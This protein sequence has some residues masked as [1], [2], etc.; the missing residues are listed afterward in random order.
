MNNIFIKANEQGHTCIGSV[1]TGKGRTQSNVFIKSTA[2]SN[3]CIGSVMTGKGRT[4]SKTNFFT[5]LI[6]ILLLVLGVG[7][8]AWAATETYTFTSK[9]WGATKSG[10][11]TANW[12]S[13]KD[14]NQMQ[15]GRGIQVTT[16]ASGANGTS[17]VSFSNVSQVVVTYSTNA[18]SGAG[19]IAVKIGDNTAVSQSVTKS[20][21]TTDRTLTYNFS[22]NQTGNVKVTV[23]CTTNSIY[24]KSVA[25]TESSLEDRSISIDAS[26]MNFT[27]G[28]EP[29][30]RTGSLSAGT[31]TITYSSSDND[32]ATV[33]SSTGEVTP[34]GA[35]SC[36]ITASV[37]ADGIYAAASASYTVNVTDPNN[38]SGTINFNSSGTVKGTIKISAA[39]ASGDDNLDNTWSVTTVGTDS[40]TPQTGYCQV[41]SSSSPATSITFTMT[42][43]D[44]VTFKSFSGNFGGFSGTA[45]DITLKVDDNVVGTGSLVSGNND[46]T[47]TATALPADGRILTITITNISKGVICRSISYTYGDSSTPSV[48]LNKSE[49]SIEVG[50]TE[51]LTAT[52]KNPSDATVTWSTDNGSVATVS[53]A[54][55]VTAVGVGTAHIIVALESDNTVSDTCTVT[56]TAIPRTVSVDGSGTME[57]TVGGET[58]TRTASPSEGDDAVTYSSSDTRV[59]TVNPSTG[60]VTAVGDGSCT[61]TASVDESGNYA[62]ASATYTV[63]VTDPSLMTYTWNLTTSSYSSADVSSVQWTAE[64]ASMTLDKGESGTNAN[65]YLGGVDSHNQTRFYT[66]QNLTFAPETEYEIIKVEFTCSTESYATTLAGQTWDNASSVS[67]STKV[68]ITPTDRTQDFSCTLSGQV[69]GLG[70]TVYYKTVKEYAATI[71]G[72]SPASP[73]T[74]GNTGT[75]EV[76]V[77]YEADESTCTT[78]FAT[79]DGT[80]LSV[81]P[82]TG[83]FEALQNGNVDITVTITTSSTDYA[84]VS[85]TFNYTVMA[86]SVASDYVIDYN[87]LFMKCSQTANNKRFDYSEDCVLT[88]DGKKAIDPDPS[89]VWRIA[90][91]GDY[92]TIYNVAAKKYAASASGDNAVQLLSSGTADAALWTMVYDSDT[93]T[94]DFI[95][96]V[97]G[98]DSGNTFNQYLRNY[99]AYGFSCYKSGTGGS[100]TL[101]PIETG[102]WVYLNKRATGLDVNWTELLTAKTRD[103]GTTVNWESSDPTT[104]SISGEGNSRTITGL[105]EGT[106][107]ITVSHST[108]S[109]SSS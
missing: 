36:T 96:K 9:S 72:I 98:I 73:L 90:R 65:N 39:S 43:A 77:D 15:S 14:G 56:V 106:A 23:N 102:P 83:A 103:A 35:G 101:H 86:T 84:T 100:L 58:Q 48:K 85:K 69:R 26:D 109:S 13:G 49:T 62:A 40:F 1:M 87:G 74:L 44:D 51:P 17:P 47:V 46:I 31:G 105:K 88:A 99:G 71:T 32:V 64:C 11:T 89:I 80:I 4:Q 66:S 75:F 24:I 21:G 25:I 19:S 52:T 2:Q 61:I 82:T 16:G 78:T 33:N 5:R 91:S 92:Y 81:D 53:N 108:W 22:P 57:L 12:T 7:I 37:P 55:V 67:Y 10:G 8:N 107:T 41:G 94:Y 20:G 34:V 3:A 97:L 76:A 27:V 50:S 70:V 60:E 104:V 54:G 95:N 38:M 18:S 6:T 68:T 63:N 93:D 29:Q 30:T 42:L 28:G 45:G 59:A 79:S